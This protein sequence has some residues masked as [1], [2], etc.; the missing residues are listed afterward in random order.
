LDTGRRWWKSI[1]WCTH[2]VNA[3]QI[4]FKEQITSYKCISLY[5]KLIRS[6]SIS[7]GKKT[8][9]YWSLLD[10]IQWKEWWRYT[11]LRND[12]SV[13]NFFS[14]ACRSDSNWSNGRYSLVTAH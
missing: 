9:L 12:T 8:N 10:S 6:W 2:N 11:S 3:F 13:F 7:L 14:K 5:H 1:E 4:F